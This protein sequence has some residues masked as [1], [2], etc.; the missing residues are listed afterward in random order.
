MFSLKSK[1]YNVTITPEDSKVEVVRRI[2]DLIESSGYTA[3]EVNDDKPW[4][5]YFRLK[6]DQANEFVQEF[7]S[8]L[9]PEEARLNIPNAE[10]SP[11]ILL[12]SPG[13]R[14]SWQYHDRRAER[15]AFLTDGAYNKSTTDDPGETM[16]VKP[17]EVI[18]F[19]QSERH[20]LIGASKAYTIVAEIWQHVDG[21]NP[22]DEDDITRLSDDYS[23]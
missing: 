10:L 6:S 23:R 19:A 17:G 18:Q 7:F 9:S 14:L 2:Q 3:V 11:K 13:Q 1:L 8:E 5:A 21:N 12:V 4:G 16:M 15:W 22:S 20:R